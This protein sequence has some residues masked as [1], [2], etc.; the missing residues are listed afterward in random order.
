MTPPGGHP[1]LFSE[2]CYCCAL[3]FCRTARSS[4]RGKYASGGKL[5]LMSVDAE[6]DLVTD[7]KWHLTRSI[8][9]ERLAAFSDNVF[10]VII[11]IMVL[12]LRFPIEPTFRALVELWP[13]AISY[14][15][16]CVLI[17]IVWMNHHFLLRFARVSTPR[18]ILSNFAHMFPASLVPFSTAWLAETRI[19]AVPAFV[20]A[21]VILMLGLGYHALAWETFPRTEREDTTQQLRRRALTRSGVSIGLFAMAMLLSLKLPWVNFALVSLVVLTYICPELPGRRAR[22]QAAQ[23]A[24]AL[25]IRTKTARL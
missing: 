1:L 2:A 14:A 10:A 3:E 6:D 23:Q 7:R 4:S 19:A 11:T 24:D 13:T 8:T 21:S 22:L 12:Q 20:Y 25:R 15:V 9:P 16:S 18:L 17:T 5:R